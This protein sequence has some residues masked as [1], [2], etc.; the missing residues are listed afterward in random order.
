MK[1]TVA[2]ALNKTAEMWRGLP[3]SKYLIITTSFLVF[4]GGG[5]AVWINYTDAN[6]QLTESLAF[7]E[8]GTIV[9]EPVAYKK[10]MAAALV[11]PTAPVLPGVYANLTVIGSITYNAVLKLQGDGVYDYALSVGNG[12]VYKRYAHRGRWWVEGNVLH[13]ILVSGDQFLTAPESRD[14]VTPAREQILAVT[15]DMLT[16]QA[17][18]GPAVIFRKID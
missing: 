10:V 3:R 8:K 1:Q 2:T 18:Y 5:L 4:F 13:T 11:Q 17:H 16:L 12:R 7:V 15:P 9:D 6:R 14:K